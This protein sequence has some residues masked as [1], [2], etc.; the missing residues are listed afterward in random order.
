MAS[1][2]LRCFKLFTSRSI[3]STWLEE[4]L[5]VKME[6]EME[7]ELLEIRQMLEAKIRQILEAIETPL[8]HSEL[9]MLETE[10]RLIHRELEMQ[11]KKVSV[12]IPSL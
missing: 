11:P 10:T 2:V 5:I 3:R 1:H 7:M 12:Q 4:V 9:K 6:M 8:I